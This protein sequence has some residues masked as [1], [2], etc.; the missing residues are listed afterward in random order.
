MPGLS[1]RRAVRDDGGMLHMW[2]NHP[3]TRAA[4]G[5]A[6]PIDP[7]EH[8]RWFYALLGDP[9]RVLWIAVRNGAPVGSIRFDRAGLGHVVSIQ[10]DPQLRGAGLGGRLLAAGLEKARID[11]RAARL[12]AHIRPDNAASRAM[13]RR[14]GFVETAGP[15]PDG[16]TIW[17]LDF[18]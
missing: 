10:I 12:I 14:A 5:A 16:M 6:A 13:F 4:S 3:S 9:D 17:H 15:A 18:A 8:W 2:R 11:L 1:L 7:A